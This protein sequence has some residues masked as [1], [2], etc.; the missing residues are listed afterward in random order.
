MKRG[1]HYQGILPTG[2]ASMLNNVSAE[3][4]GNVCRRAKSFL[5]TGV[6][7]FRCAFPQSLDLC[8]ERQEI[9]VSAHLGTSWIRQLFFTWLGSR[10]LGR[11]RGLFLWR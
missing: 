7:L 10:K 6:K 1:L 11:D 2:K 4:A 3:L 5:T 8:A 9:R